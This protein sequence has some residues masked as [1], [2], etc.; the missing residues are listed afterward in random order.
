MS[1]TSAIQLESQI[2]EGRLSENSLVGFVRV[3]GDMAKGELDYDAVQSL[4][5]IADDT[6]LPESVRSEALKQ[7]GKK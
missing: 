3:L 2:R 7:L 5:R 6:R 4:K 1:Y